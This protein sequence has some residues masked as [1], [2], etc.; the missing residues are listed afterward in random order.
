LLCFI[1]NCHPFLTNQVMFVCVLGG[2]GCSV[3]SG[4]VDTVLE[5]RGCI[6][7]LFLFSCHLAGEVDGLKEPDIHKICLNEQS[8][9][10]IHKRDLYV[11]YQP[12]FLLHIGV[13][14]L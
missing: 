2:G 3:I 6:I 12:G 7:Y 10:P 9:M 13:C 5:R 4:G 1:E 11:W 14:L 8:N